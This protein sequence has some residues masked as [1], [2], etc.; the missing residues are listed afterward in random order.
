[1][2]FP[3]SNYSNHGTFDTKPSDRL[4]RH[5][6]S[7]AVIRGGQQ[8]AVISLTMPLCAPAILSRSWFN[9]NLPG[10]THLGPGVGLKKTSRGFKFQGNATIADFLSKDRA[11]Y[12]RLTSII[13]SFGTGKLRMVDQL[14]REI[15]T[16]PMCLR[17]AGSTGF[18]TKSFVMTYI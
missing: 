9:F 1:M 3:G 12:A 4:L 11:P 18:A 2:R 14:G 15:I 6:R 10:I 17:Q 8:S 16:V 7:G 5:A 13:N